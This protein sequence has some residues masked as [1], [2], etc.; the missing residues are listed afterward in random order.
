MALGFL[1]LLKWIKAVTR[2]ELVKTNC[3]NVYK[4]FC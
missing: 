4:I 1:F 2:F 3:F